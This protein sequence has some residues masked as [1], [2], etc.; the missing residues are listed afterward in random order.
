[1]AAVYASIASYHATY[2]KHCG[3]FSSP[4]LEQILLTIGTK[5]IK[6][7]GDRCK[8]NSLNGTPKNILHVVF[9][10]WS[11]GGHSRLIWRWIQQDNQRVHSVVLTQQ[12]IASVPK[13]LKD[14]VFNSHGK[15]YTLNKTIGSYIAKA[16]RLR[17]IAASADVVVL[18]TIDDIIPII[19]FADKQKS[20]PVIFVNHADERFWLGVGIADIVANLRKSG[21]KLSRERRGI[22]AERNTLLPTIVEPIQ[23][24]LSQAEAKRQLGLPEKSILLLSIARAVKYKTIDGTNFADAHVPLLK[25]YEQGILIVVGPGEKEDWSAAIQQTQGRIKVFA[26]RE[27]T[28]VFYQAADIYV[29]SFPFVSITSLLEAGSYGVPLVSRYPYSDECQILGADMP[30]LTGNLIRV[31]DIE[32][33]IAVLSHLVENEEFRLCLGERTKKQ[34][35]NIHTTSNWQ[36]FLED[37]YVRVNTVP[38]IDLR[39]VTSDRIF[40]GEPDIFLQRAFYQL[41]NKEHINI[42]E[43]IQNNV[44]FMPFDE[45]LRLWFKLLKMRGFGRMGRLNLLLPQWLHWRLSQLFMKLPSIKL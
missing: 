11:I 28:A 34:I 12:S 33:Y 38:R 45:R 7:K 10:V 39:T 27:D 26:E 43:T 35:V 1:M 36:C 31:R 42:D 15:I 25:Q 29:D 32:E 44:G 5:A 37:L 19:A 30:G 41:P 18:H 13:S 22:E 9:G 2:I 20:P 16:K 3:L 21:M 8:N 23:R 17:E 40:L 24:V 4:E 6:S 14:S